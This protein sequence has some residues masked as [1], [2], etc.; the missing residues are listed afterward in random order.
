[1]DSSFISAAIEVYPSRQPNTAIAVCSG[2]RQVQTFIRSTRS[3][4]ARSV[5]RTPAF[6]SG[7]RPLGKLSSMTR[8]CGASVLTKGAMYVF[9]SVTTSSVLSKPRSFSVLETDASGR[10]VIL[11]IIDHGNDT[12]FGSLT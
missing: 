9:L 12:F 2:F 10:G 8:Y 11:S 6:S 4:V 7:G 5:K 1:M 3:T